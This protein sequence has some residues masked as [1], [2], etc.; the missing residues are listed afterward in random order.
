MRSLASQLFHTVA[1]RYGQLVMRF[2]SLLVVATHLALIV[3]AHLTAF[4]LRFEGNIQP[5]FDVIMWRYLPAV[6][7]IYWGG[8]WVFGIQRGLWRYV[9]L[10][11][12]GRIAHG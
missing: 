4:L 8:L 7:L 12:L 3:A 2:R 1:G 11:D 10:H 9:G 5:P 6:L